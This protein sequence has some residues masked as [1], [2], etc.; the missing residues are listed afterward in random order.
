[1]RVKV[2]QVGLGQCI[3]AVLLQVLCHATPI[4]S[5]ALTTVLPLRCA[6]SLTPSQPSTLLL[7]LQ[8]YSRLLRDNA[9]AGPK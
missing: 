6:T 7:P 9:P 5:Q 3:D 2:M 8:D 4:T 1:M